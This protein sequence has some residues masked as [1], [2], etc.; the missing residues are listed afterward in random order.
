MSYLVQVI[1][2]GKIGLIE[3]RYVMEIFNS[4]ALTQKQRF[5]RALLLGIPLSLILAVVFGY[6]H[7]FIPS[8]ILLVL[9]SYLIAMALQKLGRGVQKRFSILGVVL[10]S[11]AILIA[12]VVY[13]YGVG[14]LLD[15]EAYL[16]TIQ[17]V[18]QDDFSS[19]LGLVYRVAGIYIAY[20]YSRII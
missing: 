17:L 19:I 20:T 10:V 9:M 18:V 6:I 13:F 15:F 8:S 4:R 1:K 12:D 11:F 16:T 2:C 7:R 3:R 14:S 5:N